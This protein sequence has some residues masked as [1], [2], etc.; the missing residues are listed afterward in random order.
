MALDGLSGYSAVIDNAAATA[1]ADKTKSELGSAVSSAG[2]SGTSSG[3]KVSSE[4][5]MSACKQFEAYLWEQVYK[6]MKKSSTTFG[7]D[8]DSNDYGMNMVNLF[9]DKAIETVSSESVT[10][11]PNSL[12]QTLY[13]QLKRNYNIEE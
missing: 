2:T 11:G 13:D 7:D 4:K 6:E 5:L 12:A 3:D 10:Q 1:Q 8:S 9:M